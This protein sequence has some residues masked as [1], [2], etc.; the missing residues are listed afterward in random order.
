LRL[1]KSSFL[2]A[3]VT[4]FSIFGFSATASA[5]F[6]ASMAVVGRV[7]PN[8]L[9]KI[10]SRGTDFGGGVSEYCFTPLSLSQM[11]CA[12]TTLEIINDAIKL[13]AKKMYVF[14]MID[15]NVLE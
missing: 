9:F 14:F 2:L 1:L 4:G 8:G 15:S 12:N 13:D 3:V 11:Y 6:F 5:G 10:F 7:V